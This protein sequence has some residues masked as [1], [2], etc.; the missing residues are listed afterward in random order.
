MT[1]VINIQNLLLPNCL[2][3]FYCYLCS[4]K[5]LCVCVPVVHIWWKYYV[6]VFFRASLPSS[7]FNNVCYIGSLK[8]AVVG[9]FTSSFG[10]HYKLWHFSFARLLIC[11]IGTII[12]QC[13][14]SMFKRFCLKLVLRRDLYDIESLNCIAETSGV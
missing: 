3:T 2:T 10:K 9:A 6:M 7:T 12:T 13:L 4:L 5:C 14:H 1:Q 11:S 8:L